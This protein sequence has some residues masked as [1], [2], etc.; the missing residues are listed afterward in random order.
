MSAQGV[1]EHMLNVYY[2]HICE[3]PFR[4]L[5]DPV[6]LVCG[7][8]TCRQVTRIQTPDAMCQSYSVWS[9]FESL[10]NRERIDSW[11]SK[12]RGNSMSLKNNN[13]C[14]VQYEKKVNES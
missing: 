13:F 5:G 3:G 8:K 1:D 6:D 14:I 4:L 9:L 11:A 10:G 12:F 7:N 2:Y